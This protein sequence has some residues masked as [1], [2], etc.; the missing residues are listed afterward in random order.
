MKADKTVKKMLKTK[1]D[2]LL[3]SKK[4][5]FNICL[6]V[7]TSVVVALGLFI[8]GTQQV[9]GQSGSANGDVPG[10]TL[11][12]CIDY[13]ME[14]QPALNQARINFQITK[15]TNAINLSGWYPQAGVSATLVH[16]DQLPSTLV[17]IPGSPGSYEA[18]KTGVL[19]T[20]I[21]G[22]AVTQAIF[23]PSLL[24]AA[25][26]ATLNKQQAE[27]VTDS[28]KIGLVTNVSKTF[29]N[30][31]L[32]L[33][34]LNILREDTV[35]LAKNLSDSYHQFLGGIVDETDYEQA[36]IT[37]NNSRAQLKQA[38]ENVAPQYALLKEQIGF[39]PEK[40]FTVMFDTTEL[41]RSMVV[42]TTRQL[43]YERR[44]ELKMLNTAKLL[45]HQNTNYYKY[46][47]APSVSAFYNYNY[48]FENN[49]FSGLYQNVYPNSFLGLS[50]SIPL[51]TGM[52]RLE[53]LHRSKLQEQLLDW[54]EKDLRSHIYAQYTAALANYKSNLY[55]LNMLQQNVTLAKKVYYVV[56]LQYMQGIVAYL[57]VITAESNLIN[58]EIGYLNAMFLV[59]ANKI[60]LENAMG[61]INY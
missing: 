15:A 35:R 16:Y 39:P 3:S 10:F 14:H 40:N 55:N 30:L 34:Q 28:N 5:R 52:A 18:E 45:Q 37:L 50:L 51:F 19:N 9:S 43:D 11:R 29:Y 20:S 46:S 58:A 26:T 12:Q 57:N 53:G 22:I 47:F 27:Q 17:A 7:K 56:N 42:D 54:S 31:L 60:D 44:I 38:I 1:P 48:E 8:S 49:T 6:I 36:T 2:K 13:A 61:E 59:L 21:P 4:T 24:Y 23:S 41:L 25:K 32:T 33:E